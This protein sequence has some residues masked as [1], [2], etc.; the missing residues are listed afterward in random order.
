MS[1]YKNV[2]LTL[3]AIIFV[4][5]LIIFNGGVCLAQGDPPAQIVRVEEDW[6]MILDQPEP[7]IVA[8]QVTCVISPIGNVNSLYAAFTLNHQGMPEFSPGGM[9]MQVWNNETSITNRNYPN[10]AILSLNNETVT[11]TQTM[12][13]KDGMLTFEVINGSS[14]TWGAFGS[15]GY[16]KAIVNTTLQD[17]NSYSPDISVAKS[18]IG[19]ASNRVRSLVLEKVRYITSTGAVIEDNTDRIVHYQE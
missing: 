9:Q 15:Q 8:P 17:L 5:L 19:F 4:A 6:K 14:D 11:W 2:L 18:D 16:L 13:L 7:G 1:Y 12:E 10:N 3:N